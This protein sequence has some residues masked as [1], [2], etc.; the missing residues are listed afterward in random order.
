M[1]DT[2]EEHDPMCPRADFEQAWNGAECHCAVIRVLREVEGV[3]LMTPGDYILERITEEVSA[4]H[5]PRCPQSDPG[6]SDNCHCEL[7]N[8][9]DKWGTRS[10]T[11]REAV[12]AGI[13]LTHDPLCPPGLKATTPDRCS[14][15][16]TIRQAREEG[17]L[18]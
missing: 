4:A 11:L 10:L 9:Q 8:R 6:S 18:P 3:E 17:P 12:D 16:V 14:W 1:T 7:L 2:I 13:V 5:H 15:C